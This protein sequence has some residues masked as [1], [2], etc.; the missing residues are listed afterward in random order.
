[1]VDIKGNLEEKEVLLITNSTESLGF[2]FLLIIINHPIK[3][4]MDSLQLMF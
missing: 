4:I 2:S 3:K 1:M